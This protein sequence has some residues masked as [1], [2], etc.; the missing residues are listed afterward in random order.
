MVDIVITAANV[1]P[2]S[3]GA[4]PSRL[5]QVIWGGNVTRGQPVYLDTADSKYKV[6]DNNVAAL[7]AG[8]AGLA[9]AM[10]DGGNNQPGVVLEGGDWT[11]GGTVVVGENYFLSA[12]AGG[13]APAADL[14]STHFVSH[15]G[16]GISA[17]VIR[18][19][20]AGPLVS[21]VQKP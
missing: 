5:K 8:S 7:N 12:T 14:A 16:V 20:A 2:V 21:G 15:L 1:A 18:M 10:S 19:P 4:N 13:I 3:T 17:S 11:A 9:I 6:A